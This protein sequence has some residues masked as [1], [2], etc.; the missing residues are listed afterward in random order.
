LSTGDLI[1]ILKDAVSTAIMMAMPFLLV[2]IIIGVVISVFQA[3][4]QIH[5][6]NIIFVPKILATAVL[7]IFL[8]TWLINTIVGFTERL[9]SNINAFM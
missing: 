3:A 4:T 2:S 7:L 6:Q 5:D 9:F 8:S 1:A